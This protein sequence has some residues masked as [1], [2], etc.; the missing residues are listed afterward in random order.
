[1]IS[2]KQPKTPHQVRRIIHILDIFL[3]K[4]RHRKEDELKHEILIAFIQEK[5]PECD[6][7]IIHG[8]RITRD[9][10]GG[11]GGGGGPRTTFTCR[12]NLHQRATNHPHNLVGH[13]RSGTAA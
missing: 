6:V 13:A 12:F 1:M 10:K 3:L 7:E 4:A 5:S 8:K 9:T 11:G 2:N